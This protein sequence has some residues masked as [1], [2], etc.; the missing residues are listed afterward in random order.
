MDYTDRRNLRSEEFI[1]SHR[2]QAY[3]KQRSEAHL[4]LSWKLYL[5]RAE[6]AIYISFSQLHMAV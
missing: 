6:D 3:K 2:I 1:L 4:D 5:I